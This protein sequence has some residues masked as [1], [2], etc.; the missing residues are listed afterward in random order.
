MVEPQQKRAKLPPC[1]DDRG[2]GGQLL[3]RHDLEIIHT[4]LTRKC[5]CSLQLPDILHTLAVCNDCFS[6]HPVVQ[7]MRLREETLLYISMLTL[8]FEVSLRQQS[9]GVLCSRISQ[10]VAAGADNEGAVLD[11]LFAFLASEDSYVSYSACRALT[12]LLL[13][14]R[15]RP[16]EVVLERLVDNL[17]SSANLLEVGHSVEVVRR[18]IE[19]KDLDEHPLEGTDAESGQPDECVKITLAPA[20]TQGA[21][22]VKY[23]ATKKLDCKWYILVARLTQFI[24]E[25]TVEREHVIVS[26]LTLWESLISVKANLS[27]TDTKEFYSG[28]ERLMTPLTRQTHSVVWRKVL[29]LY[30][31][32]LCY[33]STLALQDNLAEEPCNL[34]HLLIRA[35]KDRR[36]L[37]CVPCG[38]SADRIHGGSNSRGGIEVPTAGPSTSGSATDMDRGDHTVLHKVV[39]VVLKAIAVTV[40]ETRCDSSS[41]NSSRS[42]GSGSEDVDMAIIERSLREVVRKVDDFVKSKLPFHPEAPMAEWM[43]RLFADQDDWLVESMVCGLDIFTGL[44]IRIRQQP[45]LHA[46][47]NPHTTFLVFLE[48]VYLEHDVLLDLLVSNETSF[49]LYLLRYLKFIRRSWHEFASHYGRRLEEVMTVLIRLRCAIDRLVSKNLFPYNINPVLKLLQKCEELYEGG[50]H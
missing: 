10:V 12:S 1:S 5:L 27:V 43:V 14:L 19:W 7:L 25:F 8:F 21:N 15:G 38:G 16:S 26:F 46:C 6:S 28:L 49:L 32:V 17:A 13:M 36:F 44:G 2:G 39:L 18:V 4:Q 47:V 24:N 3:P 22:E 9:R 35:V 37:E 30:N 40:K 48:T 50:D 23:V 41:E 31:E 45:E 42:G 33:G 11:I 20:D 29:D 34:A